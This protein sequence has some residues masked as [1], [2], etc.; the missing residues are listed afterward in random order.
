MSTRNTTTTTNG[1]SGQN[2]ARNS[3]SSGTGTGTGTGSSNPGRNQLS[4]QNTNGD[5]HNHSK[6]DDVDVIIVVV[7]VDDG[8]PCQQKWE[9]PIIFF[10]RTDSQ[11]FLSCLSTTSSATTK[12]HSNHDDDDDDDD[13]HH[14]NHQPHAAVHE[15]DSLSKAMEYVSNYRETLTTTRRKLASREDGSPIDNNWNANNNNNNNNNNNKN[16]SLEEKREQE[17][18]TT[19]QQTNDDELDVL[20]LDMMASAAATT[21][22]TMTTATITH[23]PTNPNSTSMTESNQTQNTTTNIDSQVTTTTTTTTTTASTNQEPP[24]DSSRKNPTSISH[25]TNTTLTSTNR[26]TRRSLPRTNHR[27]RVRSERPSNNDL[28]GDDTSMNDA[29]IVDEA[30]HQETNS[31]VEETKGGNHP[32]NST[33]PVTP[34][35]RRTTATTTPTSS[36]RKAA[37]QKSTGPKKPN[38]QKEREWEEMFLEFQ[39][40]REEN[41]DK[42]VPELIPRTPLRKWVLLQRSHYKLFKEGK[43]GRALTHEKIARLTGAGFKFQTYVRKTFHQRT[44]E[45]LEFYSKHGRDPTDSE[46]PEGLRFWMRAIRM[47]YKEHQK[48]NKT[49]LTQENIDRL[50]ALGFQ[51]VSGYKHLPQKPPEVFRTWEESFAL[52]VQYK[53]E[54]GDCLVP[55]KHPTLGDWVKRQRREYR[56]RILGK[57]GALKD[58]KLKRLESI[59]FVFLAR[60]TRR[61]EFLLVNDP[62]EVPKPPEKKV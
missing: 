59:G 27:K 6:C 21:T 57:R 47:K 54:H 26:N 8:P 55:Q 42:E 31:T 12:S 20:N 18:M 24:N 28:M 35:R 49:S 30:I 11:K 37:Y 43:S 22:T 5:N 1:T 52:L 46:G 39:K 36:P 23:D 10:S 7:L 50:N 29:V 45:W 44:L 60:K 34:K 33:L 4:C 14:H 51:W 61:K 48:G 9:A 16:T 38:P 58:D 62:R 13:N 17:H 32:K 53:E 15:F 25:P 3:S 41:G 2:V 19:I 40:W 56:R